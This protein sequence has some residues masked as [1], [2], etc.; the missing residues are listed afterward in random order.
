MLAKEGAGFIL[1]QGPRG[2]GFRETRRYIDALVR[3]H[4]DSPPYRVTFV[5]GEPRTRIDQICGNTYEGCELSPIIPGWSL[6]I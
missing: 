4:Q 3:E 5:Y 6:V 1:A 2:G